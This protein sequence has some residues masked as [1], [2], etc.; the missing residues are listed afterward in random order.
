MITTQPHGGVKAGLAGAMLALL[1]TAAPV[2]AQE[3]SAL[4]A[5]PPLA[6][7]A[8]DPD[9]VE[10]QAAAPIVEFLGGGYIGFSPECAAHGWGGTHQVMVR[11]Q[12]QG[13]G[14]N[15]SDESQLAIYF[16]TGTIAMRYDTS[17]YLSQYTHGIDQAVYVWNG[18]WIPDNA[19]M[20]ISFYSRYGERFNDGDTKVH[21][22]Y[23]RLQNFNEFPRCAATLR[24]S[25]GRN[26]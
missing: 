3:F 2:A 11:M 12:P 8:V 18:P 13:F 24:V 14:G 10:A 20:N 17:E 21:S 23:I 9:G 26:G 4:D 25:V 5:M 6:T 22:H 15:P 7:S 16:A 19:I 1:T